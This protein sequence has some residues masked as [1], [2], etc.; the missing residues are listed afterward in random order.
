MEDIELN[1][2]KINEAIKEH[3]S[4]N[5]DMHINSLPQDLLIEKGY[6]I[7]IIQSIKVVNTKEKVKQFNDIMKGINKNNIKNII[8][9]LV[10]FN[11]IKLRQPNI[12]ISIGQPQ[13]KEKNKENNIKNDIKNVENYMQNKK[14]NISYGIFDTTPRF[15][16]I[17]MD[18]KTDKNVLNNNIENKKNK[19]YKEEIN[20]NT[21]TNNN[22][23]LETNTSKKNPFSNSEMEIDPNKNPFSNSEME[24]E[25]NKNPFSNPEVEIEYNKNLDKDNKPEVY[26]ER[27]SK[28]NTNN[29]ENNNNNN[30]DKNNNN[31]DK[32]LLQHDGDSLQLLIAVP[33]KK[34]NK[35]TG[36]LEEIYTNFCFS[37]EDDR[38][39][40]MDLMNNIENAYKCVNNLGDE[41]KKKKLDEIN[42]NMEKTIEGFN[43]LT[44]DLK[45]SKT[46]T[47]G[48]SITRTNKDG[49]SVPYTSQ[50]QS[51]VDINISDPEFTTIR[52]QLPDGKYLAIPVKNN[53]LD[54]NRTPVILDKEESN[55]TKEHTMEETQYKNSDE[56]YKKLG[57]YLSK[58]NIKIGGQE[59]S[60]AM[61]NKIN[62]VRGIQAQEKDKNVLRFTA[63]LEN[64]STP[65]NPTSITPTK[66]GLG[67]GNSKGNYTFR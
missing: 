63:P 61:L 7:P 8:E 56:A 29:K 52:L 47:K 53:Q 15:D 65:I 46:N 16:D 42:K 37:N 60:E 36:K 39:K 2:N 38:K 1:I 9:K 13:E 44:D 40:Y 30:N 58:T 24:I 6:T 5:T 67:K 35:N 32:S 34:L 21:N 51:A 62:E 41:E 55:Q 28:N 14:E 57:E 11:E 64:T 33:L 27:N 12:D 26:V 66:D 54:P 50:D 20:L 25:L 49:H 59:V 3:N 43:K 19:N 17:K 31:K 45:N 10:D 22:I 48:F 4:K 23:D 18:V